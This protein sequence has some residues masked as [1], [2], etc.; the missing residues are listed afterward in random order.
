MF[1]GYTLAVTR[2]NELIVWLLSHYLIAPLSG[3][4]I[5]MQYPIYTATMQTQATHNPLNG[6]AAV[7]GYCAFPDMHDHLRQA[8][9]STPCVLHMSMR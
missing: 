5:P 9:T 8:G 1:D 7:H 2:S 4:C 6:A 3:N